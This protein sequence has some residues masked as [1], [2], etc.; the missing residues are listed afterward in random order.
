MRASEF[1]SMR[2]TM[3]SR[4]GEVKEA[5]VMARLVTL[6]ACDEKGNRLFRDDDWPNVNELPLPAVMRVFRAAMKL[7]NLSDEDVEELAKNSRTG[8]TSG[9]GSI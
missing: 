5:E 7:N 1:N 4:N 2:A 9:S 3:T 8:Q 6:A